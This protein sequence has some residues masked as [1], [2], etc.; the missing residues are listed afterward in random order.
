MRGQTVARGGS[1][2]GLAVADGR[3]PTDAAAG[4]GVLDRIGAVKW[5]RRTADASSAE[6]GRTSLVEGRQTCVELL[7][8]SREVLR[9]LRCCRIFIGRGC[10]TE[11][12]NDPHVFVGQIGQP[13]GLLGQCR[14]LHLSGQAVQ[15]R[16]PYPKFADINFDGSGRRGFDVLVELVVVVNH[17]P[18]GV[19]I[20]RTLRHDKHNADGHDDGGYQSDCNED[21]GSRQRGLVMIGGDWGRPLRPPTGTPP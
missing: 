10:C 9:P 11:L 14:I 13:A 15:L 1:V 8:K 21:F 5:C 12:F 16:S 4:V 20:R 18:D 19:A 17:G 7:A 2:S 3:G 6:L